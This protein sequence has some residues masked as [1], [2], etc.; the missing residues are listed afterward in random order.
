MRF[1]VDNALS[2]MVAE[3]LQQAGYDAVHVR[4]YRMQSAPDKDIFYRAAAEDRILLSADTDFGMLLALRGEKKPSLILWRH[5]QRRPEMQVAI[6]LAN[7]AN[8]S[9]ILQQGGIVVFEAMRVRVRP[10]P[11]GGEREQ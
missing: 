4:D 9:E 6:L 3:G 10:L 5:P 2:P 7:L 1:L 8:I 11:I